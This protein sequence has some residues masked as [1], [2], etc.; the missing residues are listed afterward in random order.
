MNGKGN[1]VSPI[2]PQTIPPP[3]KLS[4]KN[5]YQS[6]FRLGVGDEVEVN[7]WRQES[8]NRSFVVPPNGWIS[9]PL[10]GDVQ[11]IGLT[12]LEFRDHI[13]TELAKYFFNPQVGV[14]VTT[15]RS[16][17]VHILG[18]VKRP[19]VLTIMSPISA[20][21]AISQA[22]GFTPDAKES[23]VLLIRKEEK[24]QY[25][26]HTINLKSA[27]RKGNMDENPLLHHGDILYIP[28]TFIANLDRFFRHIRPVIETLT[29]VERGIVLWPAVEDV[30]KGK[31]PVR[32]ITIEP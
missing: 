26:V 10:V 23:Q 8:L 21:E 27:I 31:R 18:E 12:P 19:G 11:V 13:R 2:S 15:F 28:P 7:V 25:E 5:P 9:F 1:I 14:M 4:E 32:V 30:F 20:V 17:R 6:V 22:A 16:A 3:E 24:N 29:E